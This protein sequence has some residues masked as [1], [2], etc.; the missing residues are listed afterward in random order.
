VKRSIQFF[1]LFLLLAVSFIASTA[2]GSVTIPFGDTVRVLLSAVS[3]KAVPGVSAMHHDI[4]LRIRIPRVLLGMVVGGGLAVSGLVFQALLKNPL[5]DPY[6]LGVSAGASF[7]AGLALFL[8]YVAGVQFKSFLPAFAFIGAVSTVFLVYF[9]ART[10]GR[11]QVLTII[12]SGVI[13]SYLF[14]SGLVLIMSLMGDKSHEI[15]FWLMGSLAGFH[16]F[17]LP[18]ACITGA[19]SLFIFSF[20]RDL[21]LISLGDEQALALGVNTEVVRIV[22][23]S[24]TSVLTAVSVSMTGT[25]GFV[26]LIIPHSMRMVFGPKHKTLIPTT[27]AA[28]AL[29]LPLSDM[30]GRVLPSVLFGSGMEVPVGVITSLFGSPFFIFLLIRGKKRLWF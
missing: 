3:G 17:L 19:L 15:V 18:A 25:I 8:S 1:L 20:Y 16:S 5:A 26:G 23:F 12:L 10:G 4:I 9:L 21:D 28:G 11:V 24:M 13:V 7:G 29:F 2:L 22:L 30:I 14:S 27:L 6:T